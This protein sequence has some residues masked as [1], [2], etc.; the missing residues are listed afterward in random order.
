MCAIPRLIDMGVEPYLLPSSLLAVLAQ[1]LVRTICPHCKEPV[2]DPEAVFA[3]LG[4][5][6]PEGMP[7]QLWQGGKCIECNHTGYRGRKGIFELMVVDERFHDAIVQRAGA[8]EYFK[9]AREAGM[10]TMFED[11]LRKT[12]GW[13]Q[14]HRST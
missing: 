1:R 7:V 11:G 6:P 4:L 2:N 13:W 10:T 5:T 14:K 8:P 12:I 3:K 9:L